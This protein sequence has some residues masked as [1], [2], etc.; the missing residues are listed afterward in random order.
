M[1]EL[2][3]KKMIM[4]LASSARVGNIA[5]FSFY[6]R[7]LRIFNFLCD[8]LPFIFC[9]ILVIGRKARSFSKKITKGLKISKHFYKVNLILG[10]FK[11]IKNNFVVVLGI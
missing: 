4:C 1:R 3:K 2:G 5:A 7:K 8:F 6:L 10:V 9:Y 11:R